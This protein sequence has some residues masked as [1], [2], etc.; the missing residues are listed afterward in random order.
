MCKPY[1]C[2]C[3]SV[4]FIIKKGGGIHHLLEHLLKQRYLFTSLT[5]LLTY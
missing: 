3:F 2:L 4:K 1:L 5:Y